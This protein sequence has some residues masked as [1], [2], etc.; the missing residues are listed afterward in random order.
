MRHAAPPLAFFF[1]CTALLAA[2]CAVPRMI[3]PQKDI[4]PAEIN[5]SSLAKRVLVASLSSEFKDAVV[6]RIRGELEG[7]AIYIR[8]V[9]LDRLD[10]EDATSY[11]AVIL[12]NTCIAWGMAR[13]VDSFLERPTD[14]RHVIIL[15]TSGDGAWLPDKKDREFDAIATASEKADVEAVAGRIISKT[16][17]LLDSRI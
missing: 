14:Y 9:G 12:I 2:G 10:E 5:S 15:T 7:E 17:T 13:E 8:I 1:A 6:A 11:D 3:W 4:A 16:K